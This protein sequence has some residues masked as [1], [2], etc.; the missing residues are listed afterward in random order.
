M[1]QT[2][3]QQKVERV[4]PDPKRRKEAFNSYVFGDNRKGKCG[5]GNDIPFVPSPVFI[6]KR[7]KRVDN[8]FHHSLAIDKQRILWSWG[9][10]NFGQLGQGEDIQNINNLRPQ[11]V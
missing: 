1:L 11:L 9:K 10:N 8:G 2:D 5:Q 3:L 6:N 7:F 4:K